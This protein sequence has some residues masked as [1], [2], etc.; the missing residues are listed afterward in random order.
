MSL[1]GVHALSFESPLLPGS[2]TEGPVRPKERLVQ[3]SKTSLV[4]K[5]LGALEIL[6]LL[7][8]GLGL[9]VGVPAGTQE[10]G[11]VLTALAQAFAYV[12]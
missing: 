12:N 9:M 8:C 6:P 2:Y 7:S 10:G 1:T 11:S 4:T 5:G 3:I